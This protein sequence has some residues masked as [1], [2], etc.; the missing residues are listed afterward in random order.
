MTMRPRRFNRLVLEALAEIPEP[1]KAHLANVDIV[2]KRRPGPSDFRASGSKRGDRLYGLYDGVPLSE[3]TGSA[4]FE[5]P[6]KITLFR[7]PLER[8]FPNESDLVREVR[9]TV[10]HEIA[11]SFGL[12]EESLAELGLD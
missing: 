10:L 11:H 3:R 5:M 2:V 12:S 7:E 1:F 4:G 8:D 9:T 6:D